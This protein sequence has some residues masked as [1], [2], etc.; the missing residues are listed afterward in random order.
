MYVL[1]KDHKKDDST[2][3]VVTGCTSNT[4]GLSNGVSDFLESVANSIPDSYEVISS[5][6]MLARIEDANKVARK[7][8]E[9][10]RA[11]KSKKMRCSMMGTSCM[12]LVERCR[13]NH[14]EEM[15]ASAGKTEMHPQE[16]SE[17]R[18]Q[19][20]LLEEGQRCTECG[21]KIEK[22]LMTECEDC[23]P[24][25]ISEDFEISLI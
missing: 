22:K 12:E 10:G 24:E 18:W 23:G 13:R 2:R 1:V 5:E 15:T 4:R 16:P 25:W 11:K 7:I 17:E 8:I 19:E 3:P 6:D 14:R 21:P 9:E 20:L